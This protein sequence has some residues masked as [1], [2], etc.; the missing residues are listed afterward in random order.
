MK[1]KKPSSIQLKLIRLVL[2][3]SGVVLF[4]T[5]TGF[6]AY[7]FFTFRQASKDRL[8]TLAEI[9]AANSTATLAFQS[10]DDASEILQALKAEKHIVAACI[11]DNHGN[12]F[13]KYP[14]AVSPKNI[15][16]HPG[17]DGFNYVNGHLEGFKPVIQENKRLGTLYLQSDMKAIYTRFQRYAMIALLVIGISVFVAYFPSKRLQ[18]TVSEPILA[19]AKTASNISNR[20]DYAVRAQKFDDDELGALTDAFNKMLTQIEQQNAEIMSFNHALE[21]KVNERTKELEQANIELKLKSDFEETIIDSSVDI[22]AVFDK[23]YRYV[24]LNKNGEEAFGVKEE[25]VIGKNILDVFP[26]LEASGMYQS[27]QEAFG[28]KE[29]IQNSKYKSYVSD[30]VLDNFF[31][32]LLDKDDNVYQVLVI[33]HDV[34][35]ISIAHEK[36]QQVNKELEKSNRD[37]EQ[38][39]FVASH[40]LQEPLRKIQTFSQLLEQKLEDKETAKK[41]LAKIIASAVRMTD[42]IKA[43][44]NYSRLSNEKGEFEQVDLNEVVDNIQTDLEVIIHE[45]GAVIQSNN[46][47]VLYGNRLQ[48]NQLFLNLISNSIKFSVRNPKINISSTLF[49]EREIKEKDGLN[50]NGKCAE[51]TFA[52]N[53]IGFEQH[54]EDKIFTVFQRLHS[55]HEYPGTGIGLALCKKIVDN[56]KGRIEVFS[57]P[58]EGS[59]FKIYLPLDHASSEV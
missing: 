46:L 55:K 26:Q 53:G 51:L 52:D 22:I 16:L 6:F 24:I 37:L 41:Y 35:E 14:S 38:F 33:G 12:I 19:L 54:F 29:M 32:P 42:L 45:R 5:C 1:Q 15:P 59:T 43:V 27:L 20:H 40:D 34:T 50:R 4:L 47:P 30:R 13:A 9:I 8:S 57:K 7:E 11:Y 25:Y 31:I 3:T 2:V 58:G 21:A 28:H 39:A 48:L 10:P 44:L 56:H 36:L 18:K 17:I 49:D 23:D